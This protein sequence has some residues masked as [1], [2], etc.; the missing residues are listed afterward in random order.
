MKRSDVNNHI[1]R[2]MARLRA[3]RFDDPLLATRITQSQNK[4]NIR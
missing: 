1:H 4:E 2:G 3:D